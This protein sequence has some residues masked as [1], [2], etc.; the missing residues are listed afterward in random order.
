LNTPGPNVAAEAFVQRNDAQ[1]IDQFAT[2]EHLYYF[3]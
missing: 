1:P 2:S 3:S